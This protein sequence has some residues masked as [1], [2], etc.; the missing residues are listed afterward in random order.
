MALAYNLIP[1]WITF[2]VCP[3]NMLG[4]TRTVFTFDIVDDTFLEASLFVETLGFLTL[5]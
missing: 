3:T 5:F 4:S 2:E 1:I